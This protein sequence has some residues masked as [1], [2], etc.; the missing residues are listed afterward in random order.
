MVKNTKGG[1]KHKKMARK[2]TAPTSQEKIRF[3]SCEDEIYASVAKI[4]G[5][6]RILVTCNDNIERQC[7]IRKKFRGKN[8]RH[9]EVSIGTYVLVGKREWETTST[10]KEVTDL[11]YV[12]SSE[13]VMGLKK[14][15]VI[16]S[17]VL[18]C[19]EKD[20]GNK[21]DKN[22]TEFMDEIKEEEDG[23][24]KFYEE[25][26]EE[27]TEYNGFVYEEKVNVDDI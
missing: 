10:N 2:S 18:S 22:Y 20:F 3:S 16:N 19:N 13:Q 6:G 27:E 15:Q 4:Y 5:N 24:I 23:D 25:S 7:V 8:K 26:S 9:N 11:L 17:K 14:N 12:Y 1:N 21:E